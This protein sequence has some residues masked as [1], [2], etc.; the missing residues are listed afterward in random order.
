MPKFAIYSGP[1]LIGWSDLESGDPPMGVASGKMIPSE[2]YLGLQSRIVASQ[3]SG[4]EGLNLTVRIVGGEMIQ[5]RAGV[6][7]TDYSKDLG[8]E[9]IEV[10]VLGVV[11]PPYASLFPE[12][13]AAY[14]RQF[15]EKG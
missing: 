5:S 12:H 13:L 6:H 9:G 11:V 3:D 2:D 10:S 14:E 8:P 15:R 7:I 1:L 4:H